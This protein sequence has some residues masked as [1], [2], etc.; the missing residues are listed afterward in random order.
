[1]YAGNHSIAH[2][3]GDLLSAAKRRTSAGNL[4]F[5][6]LGGGLAK[7]EIDE[8]IG[9]EHP[10]HV[11]S[12]PYQPLERVHGHLSMADVHVVV[13]G[14][15]TVG[16]VHPSKLYGALAAGRPVLVIG[17]DNS[18]AARIVREHGVG[19]AVEHGDTVA[20]ERVLTEIENA[21]TDQLKQMGAA[22]RTLAENQYS[23]QTLIGRV[24][25]ML[26]GASASI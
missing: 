11:L 18:P 21:S 17:P 3:L 2:P 13:V 7:V 8:W 4:R 14:E 19:W 12:L 22:A 5:V 15:S 6:F 26:E 16:I 10:K 20:L 1:M 25:T 9:K 23:R 24:V